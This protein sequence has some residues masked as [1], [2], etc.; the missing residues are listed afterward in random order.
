MISRRALVAWIICLLISGLAASSSLADPNENTELILHAVL[1]FGPC[2]IA[3][4][5][6]MGPQVEIMKP[7]EWYTI[8]VIARNY[9]NIEGVDLSA[10]WDPGFAVA[11]VDDCAGCFDC[12]LIGQ[13]QLWWSHSFADCQ[14]GGQSVVVGRIHAM[15]T[16]GCL[17]ISQ[18]GPFEAAAISCKG[19]PD[20]IGGQNLG[21]VCVGP[22]GVGI[23]SG[24][25]SVEPRTWG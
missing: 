3:D 13:N 14:A 7:G 20:A 1:G 25:V 9:D 2:E 15:P 6:V 17:A 11:Y 8:Y 24:P 23:C 22:G 21:R 10:T 18:S 5:C 16:E 19:Q 12:I 4:P